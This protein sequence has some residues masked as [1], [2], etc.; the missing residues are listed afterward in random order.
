MRHSLVFLSLLAASVAAAAPR[1]PPAKPAATATACVI[2]NG[3]K[4]NNVAF[5]CTTAL[6]KTDKDSE[7]EYAVAETASQDGITFYLRHGHGVVRLEAW[8]AGKRVATSFYS[9]GRDPKQTDQLHL[10]LGAANGKYVEAGCHEVDK[11]HGL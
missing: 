4:G 2:V 6:A 7:R 5:T 11:S 10:E 8:V 9:N 1:T 3:P